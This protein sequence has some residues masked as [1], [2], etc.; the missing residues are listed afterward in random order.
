[1]EVVEHLIVGAGPAGLRAARVRAAALDDETTVVHTIARRDLDR[2]QLAWTRAAGADSA[3][4]RA[5][6]L[7]SPR[8]YFDAECTKRGH[9][10]LATTPSL[11]RTLATWFLR[12]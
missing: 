10:R 7:P 6:S 5:L 3:V 11:R 2:H 1:V 8:Q 4:R 12:G 9:D